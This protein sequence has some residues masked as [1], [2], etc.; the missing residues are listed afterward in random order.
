M[1]VLLLEIKRQS[2]TILM[3]ISVVRVVRAEGM[4]SAVQ[5][6][7]LFSGRHPRA[8]LPWPCAWPAMRVE[9]KL[10]TVHRL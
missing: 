8:T 5:Y 2:M 9:K 1:L 7:V 3:A 4:Y 10:A 6:R